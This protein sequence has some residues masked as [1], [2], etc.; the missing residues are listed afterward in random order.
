M[1]AAGDQAAYCS[2][3]GKQ[4]QAAV[5]SA[6]ADAGVQ[7]VAQDQSQSQAESQGGWSVS[8]NA[9]WRHLP[10][11]CYERKDVYGNT[12]LVQVSGILYS[13]DGHNV[14]YHGIS[15]DSCTDRHAMVA[16]LMLCAR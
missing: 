7:A 16:G 6:S 5:S 15:V 12:D 8:V 2:T 14:H 13:A 9:F 11:E 10:P 3:T 1:P 4:Q